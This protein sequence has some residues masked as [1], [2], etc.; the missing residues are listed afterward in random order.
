VLWLLPSHRTPRCV[1]SCPTDTSTPAPIRVAPKPTARR[2]KKPRIVFYNDRGYPDE[3]EDYDQLL[4][5]VDGGP[6]LRK[7]KFPT[8]PINADD[9]T[10]N[11]TFS[12]ELHGELLRSQLD[13]SHLLPEDAAALLVVIKEYWCVFDERGTFTPVRN[14]QCIIDTGTATP[15]AVK[16]IVYGPREIPIMRKCIAALEKV[17]HIRQIHDGRWLFKALL[18]PKPHQE[19]RLVDV[20]FGC[21]MHQWAIIKSRSRLRRRK[22]LHSKVP[23]QS[24]GPTM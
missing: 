19:H 9:P 24:N 7:K 21:M 23:M 18:A 4:H 3:S 2:K 16:K 6:I 10:F 22:S 11:Y 12:E 13:L 8:L 5:N 20:G 15:I 17:G 1:G 14:Y